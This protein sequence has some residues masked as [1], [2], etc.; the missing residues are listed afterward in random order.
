[1]YLS[2]SLSLSLSLPAHQGP[3]LDRPRCTSEGRAARWPGGRRRRR[4]RATAR[5]QARS[6]E[7][8]SAPRRKFEVRVT[9][10][11]ILRAYQDIHRRRQLHLF[12]ITG[13][14]E[15]GG[16]K[17]QRESERRA[18]REPM[19]LCGNRNPNASLHSS[20]GGASDFD[21]T[22]HADFGAATHPGVGGGAHRRR[23]TFD[24]C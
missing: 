12:F 2:L 22:S 16:G 9:Q 8:A 7:T 20:N 14:E 24:R 5:A 13:G 10:R 15:G 23:A 21:P 6:R 19:H 18:E 1:M 11:K 4:R 3:R 17:Q